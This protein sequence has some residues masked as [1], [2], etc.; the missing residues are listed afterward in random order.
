MHCRNRAVHPTALAS[1]TM[2]AASIDQVYKPTDQVSKLHHLGGGGGESGRS[3]SSSQTVFVNSLERSRR[4]KVWPMRKRHSVFWA[5]ARLNQHEAL[6]QQRNLESPV[7]R[8]TS[9]ITLMYFFPVETTFRTIIEKQH[10]NFSF[11]FGDRSLLLC[12]NDLEVL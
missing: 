9:R 10:W 11:I 5:G 8:W 7:Y 2:K 3:I 6:C 4:L 1:K 12:Y